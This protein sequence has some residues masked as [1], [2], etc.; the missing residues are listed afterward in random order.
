VPTVSIHAEGDVAIEAPHGELRLVA[1][2]MTTHV[3]TDALREVKGRVVDKVTGPVTLASEARL[4][5][6]G[7]EV[8]VVA[9]GG[10][11]AHAGGTHTL[12]GGLVTL[13]P[14]GA[15]APGVDAQ[16]PPKAASAWGPRPVPGPGPGRSTEDPRTPTRRELAARAEPASLTAPAP[17][18]TEPATPALQLASYRPGGD[19]GRDRPRDCG[20][21]WD[22]AHAATRA[23]LARGGDANP[24]ERNRHISAAYAELYQDKPELLWS[25]LAAITSA[26]AG[27]AMQ[28]AAPIARMEG[29]GERANV[30]VTPSAPETAGTG[31]GVAVWDRAGREAATVARGTADTNE[32]IFEDIYPAM[33]AYRAHG[34]GAVTGPP[35][36]PGG[37]GGPA[38][39]GGPPR[40][41][42]P[43]Q[44]AFA[45]VERQP[46]TAADLMA[47]Y[48]QTMV[49]SRLYDRRP[50]LTAAMRDVQRYAGMPVV[51]WLGG[52]LFGLRKPEI[53]VSAACSGDAPVPLDGDITVVQDRV[54]Y[55]AKLMD[56]MERQRRQ[57]PERLGRTIRTIADRAR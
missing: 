23:V 16:V 27:C 15:Q 22:E 52:A 43:L 18:S 45:R 21:I 56:E 41:P 33:H 8:A 36:T 50:E 9:G 34:V 25:G 57:T 4:A 54:D 53:P 14:A 24:L 2:R 3:A 6:K 48:A 49:Q 28:Q 35:E 19:G 38:T 20:R 11:H 1:K 46:R 51:G 12:T 13:N 42:R 47:E 55:Y 40:V 26:Q 5:F 30:P 10:L 17:S 39:P 29:V 37:C 32:L 31:L 44:L 7:G